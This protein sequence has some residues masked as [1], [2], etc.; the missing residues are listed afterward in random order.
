MRTTNAQRLGLAY[1]RNV[2]DKTRD[3]RVKYPDPRV[4]AALLAKDLLC[5]L[6][7][8]YGPV[9][10]I[11]VEGRDALN[12]AERKRYRGRRGVERALNEV[13]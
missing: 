9:Y 8:H 4:I 13:P 2:A 5:V 6:G 10:A 7:H 3:P 11:T 12:A 1:F